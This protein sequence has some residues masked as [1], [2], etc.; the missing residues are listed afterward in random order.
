VTYQKSPRARWWNRAITSKSSSTNII[1]AAQRKGIGSTCG[2]VASPEVGPGVTVGTMQT[3]YPCAQD[4]KHQ[5]HDSRPVPGAR[6]LWLR[7]V[8]LGTEHA[9]YQERA[10]VSPCAPWHIA[11]HPPGKGFGVITCPEAPGPPLS[12][13]ARPCAGRLWRHHVT[14]APGPPPSTAPVSPRVLW[15]QARL[16]V[17]EGSGAAMCPVALAPQV[18]PCIPKMSDIRLIMA[19]SG[20][21]CRQCI[22]C[23]CDKPYAAYG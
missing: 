15:L 9:T 2:F 1:K 7:H 17:Q 10:S 20:T 22:K 21:R 14:E 12:E 19:S 8:P 13:E 6:E 4:L 16:L 18:C 23:V 3:G 11:R 5:P